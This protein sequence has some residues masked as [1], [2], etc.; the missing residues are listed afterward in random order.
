VTSIRTRSSALKVLYL[1]PQPK[2]AG[3]IGAYTFL[4]EEVRGLADAGIDAYVLS[5]ATPAD[6][7]VGRVHL[8]SSS[9][10]ESLSAQVGAA[11]FL[12]RS[13][14]GIPSLNMLQPVSSYRQ[15]RLEHL[16]AAIVK[17]EGIDLIHSHF[18]WPQGFGGSLAQAATQRPL[19]ASLR[20]TDIL[21]DE[22]IGYG[23]RVDPAFDR[24]LR[25]LLK[26][27]D[28]TV[29]YSNYMRDRGVALGAR[30]EAARVIRKGVDLGQ[31][32]VVPDRVAVRRELGLGDV[33]MVLTVAGLIERKGIHHILAALAQ[34][35]A[36]PF[37][38]VVCGDGPERPRLEALAREL[39]IADRVRFVGRI[40]RDTI[41]K[42]F[43]ACDVFVLASILEAAGNVLFEA[44]AAGR[45]VVC[46]DSGGP[47]EYVVE[48]ETGFVVPVGDTAAL[49]DRIWLLL[50]N[51][52]L[53][54]LL[55]AEGRRRAL[56]EFN[57][58]RMVADL[59]DVYDEVLSG[60]SVQTK[61]A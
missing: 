56:S 37:T 14:D 36:V 8:R 34:I 27:A 49:A 41:A 29:Y 23:R 19:V 10:R 13:A 3:R 5:T 17:E 32:T 48:E 44:M 52:E 6:V 11:A 35:R 50:K 26:S 47:G 25:R 20:G 28:R 22:T 55:G 4:D 45:P 1:L 24:A 31:F 59:V 58:D 18:A 12:A 43:G 53:Q 57:Y 9:A 21:L 2:D 61:T 51:P 33:P 15:A 54:D 16:A 7:T 40:D 30:P 39:G 46:T 38:F 60:R 42:Y